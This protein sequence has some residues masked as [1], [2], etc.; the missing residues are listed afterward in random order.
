MELTLHF[1]QPGYI[2][3]PYWP[4]M[5]QLIEIDKKSGINRA[6]TEANRRRALQAYLEAADMTLAGY[7]A[8]RIQAQ[9]PFHFRN[10]GPIYIPREKILACLVNASDVAAAKLRIPNLRT[11]VRATDFTTTKTQPDGVWERFAVVTMGTGAKASNQ[12]GLRRNDYLCDF[13]ASGNIEV[14]P[15]MVEPRAVVDLL[16]FAGRSVGIGACRG[17]GWG[18]FTAVVVP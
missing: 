18:R 14:E 7:E 5:Y 12:R 1:G 16:A 9:R 4:E 15:D 10:G 11:A 2:E 17:M 13:D 3:H 6:R 8:L